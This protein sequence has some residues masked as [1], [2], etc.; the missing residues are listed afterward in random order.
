MTSILRNHQVRLQAIGTYIVMSLLREVDINQNI[1]CI[2]YN[3]LWKDFTA[4][5]AS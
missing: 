2:A 1:T 3:V 4:D 5:R